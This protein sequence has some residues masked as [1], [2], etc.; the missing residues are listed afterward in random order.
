MTGRN[1]SFIGAADRRIF[2]EIAVTI[3]VA[4]IGRVVFEA[5]RFF[6]F[7]TPQECIRNHTGD[8]AHA[9][10]HVPHRKK[11]CR[12]LIFRYEY[13]SEQNSDAGENNS[14]SSGIET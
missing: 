3:H 1:I 4:G 5:K 6:A 8:T 14:Q 12:W 2:H 13:A 11:S 9:A 7:H 10:N